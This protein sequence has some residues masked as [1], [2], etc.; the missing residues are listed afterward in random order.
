MACKTEK[1]ENTKIAQELPAL[2]TFMTGVNKKDKV[3]G[4]KIHFAFCN[5]KR[6]G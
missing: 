2:K 6:H 3:S 1:I 4:L 5:R